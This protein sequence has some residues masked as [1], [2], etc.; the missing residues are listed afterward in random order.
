VTD[1]KAMLTTSCQGFSCEQLWY[2]TV[3]WY[4]RNGT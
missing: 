2:V 3:R 1:Q 4:G